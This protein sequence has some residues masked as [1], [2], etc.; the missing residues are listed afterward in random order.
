MIGPMR[1]LPPDDKGKTSRADEFAEKHKKVERAREVD[2]EE[3][4]R[5]KFRQ[6][7]EKETESKAAPEEK[8]PSP[9]ETTFYDKG[10]AEKQEPVK[11]V[12]QKSELGKEEKS[13][14]SKEGGMEEAKEYD[15]KKPVSPKHP[16]ESKEAKVTT[17]LPPKPDERI[18][19]KH[20]ES[21]KDVEAP[22]AKE[23][24]EEKKKETETPLPSLPIAMPAEI[25]QKASEITNSVKVFLNPEIAP[26]FE[27]M[28]G[29]M[30]IMSA[31]EG[32][33]QTQIDLTSANFE[34]SVF[35]GSSVVLEKYAT[36]PDSF[37]IRLTGSPEAV[38][39]FNAN[40]ESLM[41][42]FQKSNLN[43]RIGRLEA[44]HETTRPLFRRKR[45][46]SGGDMSGE[47]LGK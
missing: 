41:E 43:F 26:L 9:Y 46:A 36:A 1:P 10:P 13:I 39:I 45:S 19:Q 15:K 18:E 5:R 33:M 21:E 42:A 20:L 8:K 7:F 35:F 11:G 2:P 25:V 40:M 31:K 23:E 6:H 22:K 38:T 44:A 4:K 29:R 16:T 27:Q 17:Y 12:E 32:I 47:D 28:V 14:S 24:P 30:V 3:K 34:N 37:N